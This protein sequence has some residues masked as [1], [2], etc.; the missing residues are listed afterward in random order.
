ML[1]NIRRDNNLS[2]PTT[3]IEKM[4]ISTIQNQKPESRIKDPPA[5]THKS[6]LREW[7]S[8]DLHL[9]DY[10]KALDLQLQL[11]N[12]RHD[13]I[14]ETDAVLFLEHP[15]VFTLGRRG[16]LQSLKV[17]K[18]FLESQGIPVI[19]VERGGD[20]TYHGP[21]QLVV[22]PIMDL[23]ASG[24]GVVDF[25]EA[26]EGVM[27]RTLM[28]WGIKAARNHKNRGVWVGSSKIGSIGIAVRRSISFHGLAL[29]VNTD[30]EPFNWVH[31]CGLQGV[32]M[33]S[34]KEIMGKE[35]LMEDVRRATATHIQEVFGVR[36]K[37][38]TLDEI[39]HLLESGIP[40][41]NRKAI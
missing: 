11:V 16:N 23:R 26:L 18:S 41:L 33:I 2:I 34:M 8:L 12:A 13:R 28:D 27:I 15:P 14:L 17:P 37:P 40:A 3:L 29:N 4:A 7:L 36:L 32:C 25:V 35:L 20:M 24:W 21:G 9:I 10:R 38:K 6:T 5:S 31:P 1:I 39:L 19:P 22:Y 30:L